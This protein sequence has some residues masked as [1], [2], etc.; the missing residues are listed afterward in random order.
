[1]VIKGF[2]PFLFVFSTCNDIFEVDF[3]DMMLDVALGGLIN[4]HVKLIRK[5]IDIWRKLY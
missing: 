5:S 3:S 2:G 1:M 4:G